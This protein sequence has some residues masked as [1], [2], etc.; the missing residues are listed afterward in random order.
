MIISVVSPSFNQGKFLFKTL[1][2]VFKQRGNFY[3]DYIVQDGG[4]VDDSIGIIKTFESRLNREKVALIN[5]GIEFY[6]SYN[7]NCLGL[8]YRWVSQRDGG[9]AAALNSGFS[10]A[11]GKIYCWLN[12]DDYFTDSDVLAKVA[13][14]YPRMKAANPVF[15]DCIALD[16]D[17]QEKWRTRFG[18]A[19]FGLYDVLY[20]EFSPPQPSVF[21]PA[22]LWQAVGGL[23]PELRYELDKDL[24]I[25]MLRRGGRFLFIGG[26]LS[27]QVYH[28]D[29]KSMEGDRPFAAFEAEH[30]AVHREHKKALGWKGWGFALRL[31]LEKSLESLKKTVKKWLGRPV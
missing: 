14:A 10:K 12:S 22:E 20:K 4:S 24:W 8:S 29:S 6:P 17:G 16:Q 15:G 23:R 30:Q 11:V 1:D 18:H 2:S 31:S 27:V 19:S 5:R 7:G 21:F 9:Q 13:A 28:P 3:I 26:D 25:R